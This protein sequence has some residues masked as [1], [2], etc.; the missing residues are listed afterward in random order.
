MM[1]WIREERTDAAANIAEQGSEK[2][3]AMPSA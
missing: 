1:A 2:V 3:A